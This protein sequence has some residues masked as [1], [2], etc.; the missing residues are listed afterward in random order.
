MAFD[1][2]GARRYGGRWNSI[3]TPVVYVAESQSLAVLEMMVHL[4]ADAA[5][6]YLVIPIEFEE[7]YVDTL[8]AS[9]LPKDWMTEPAPQTTQS[10]GDNWVAGMSNVLLKV[11]SKIVR[12]EHNYVINPNHPSF[13]KITI[14]KPRNFV[15]DPRL[16]SSIS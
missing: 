10:L 13:S 1:G 6:Q 2:E 4:G 5:D 12:D 3:G 16:M 7:K 14:G 8:P 15:M 9:G 11:P